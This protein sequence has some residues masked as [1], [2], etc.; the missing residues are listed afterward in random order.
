MSTD[1]TARLDRIAERYAAKPAVS[2]MSIAAD[3]PRSGVTWR[4]GSADRPY[5]IASITKLFTAA[6]T[7]QLRSEG[8]I[9]LDTCVADVLGVQTLQGLVVHDGIDYAAQITVRQL[10]AQTSGIPDVY[11]Q[12]GADGTALAERVLDEDRYLSFDEMLELARQLPSPIAPGQAGKAHYSDTNYQ[13]LGRVVETCT[14]EHFETAVRRRVIEPLGLHSTWHF[15]LDTLDRYDEVAPVL[16]GRRRFRIP[17]ALASSLPDG[18]IVSTAADQLRFLRAFT[19]GEL[20]P[21]AYLDEMTALW[22]RLIGDGDFGPLRYGVGLMRFTLPRWQTLFIRLPA[23]IGHSGSLGTVLYH[24][25]ESDL[26]VAG[27]VNQTTPRSL[28]YPLLA[29]LSMVLR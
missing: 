26:Y 23:M 10:L 22:N 29:R 15:T 18:S 3:Q 19:N 14:A 1:A 16:Q 27:T 13:L 28:P 21:K 25:P 17:G 9:T 4:W 8:A 7:M 20:F 11:E 5:F 12:R 6:V 24:A 2:E